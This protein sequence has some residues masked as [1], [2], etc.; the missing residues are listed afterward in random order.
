MVNYTSPYKRAETN[1][2]YNDFVDM[3][4]DG[5]AQQ[6][7]CFQCWDKNKN[8][9]ND[10]NEDLNAD[11]VFNEVDCRVKGA[12]L[13]H[14]NNIWAYVLACVLLYILFRKYFLKENH[15]LAFLAALIFF[16]HPLHSE[17]IANIKG[18][19]EI[20]ASIFMTLTFLFSFKFIENK[21]TT[22]LLTASVMCL[23]ALLSKEYSLMLLLLIPIALIVF[24]KIKIDW[25]RLTMLL[26]VY[27]L[28]FFAMI[29]IKAYFAPAISPIYMILV[30]ILFF[31]VISA[32]VFRKTF[33][34]KDLNTLMMGLFSFS[35][36]YF[37]LRLNAVS[38]AAGIQDTELF[39]DPYL[40]ATGEE[41]IATKIYVLLKYIVLAIFPKNLTSDYSY[42]SI[43][44]RSFTDLSFLFS[45]VLNLA[46]LITG[47]ILVVKRH[48]IGFAIISCF[49]FLF[50]VTNFIFAI[51]T[52]MHESFMFHA[53]IGVAIAFAWLILLGIEKLLLI[54]F[55]SRRGILLGCLMLVV[56]LYGCKTW[57]RNWD[58][59]NDVTL[60]L[61][62]VKS[63]PNSVLISGNA[64]A[65]W[66]DL[67]DT[68]EITGIIPESE[69]KVFNDYN[70]TL[71]ITDEEMK[72]GGFKTKREAALYRGIGYL[73]HAVKLHPHYVN[74]YLN[75]GLA[76]FKLQKD[77]ETVY[78]W[79]LAE[80]F[81][82]NN[83]Y[84][85][86]YYRVFANVLNNR[87]SEASNKSNFKEAA[88]LYNFWTLIDPKNDEA[89]YSLGG[90]AFN[91]GNYSKAL[92]F[93]EK[94][95]VI[96]PSS[97]K[98]KA[99]LKQVVF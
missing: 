16:T 38:I 52:T 28:V 10:F 82:P 36:L 59:K 9:I 23:L 78:Y 49:A 83:P 6:D 73:E 88:V 81:Y 37:G 84:L 5:M 72:A 1:Y 14:L 29:L 26:V 58:W 35:L 91:Q 71:K 15:D 44:Y 48:V 30:G 50:L 67:A 8:F 13:R 34:K 85:A 51:G 11:G 62:D 63:N 22:T 60:F 41:K 33:V 17:V 43:N 54:P 4:S 47:I 39:N 31:T 89:L 97:E 66:I 65:R 68:K 20:L 56:F 80:H 98:T 55:S 40:L 96:N 18:R 19:A 42:A 75:L 76:Y 7:E 12:W 70:G 61:K 24:N 77:F 74:G 95:L 53:L 3:N 94:A 2:E 32:V 64:G 90:A 92:A 25:I 21:K 46:L 57:E 45:L 69:S 86:D 99:A 93:W 87:G 79:K 27:L